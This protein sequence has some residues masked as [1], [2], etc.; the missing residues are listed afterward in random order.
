MR[1]DKDITH[2]KKKAEKFQGNILQDPVVRQKLMEKDQEYQ[3]KKEREKQDSSRKKKRTDLG[4][5]SLE[6]LEDTN[7]MDFADPEEEE[8]TKNKQSLFGKFRKSSNAE[9]VHSMPNNTRGTE[10]SNF[11]EISQDDMVNLSA[12]RK[13]KRPVERA[14]M[15]TS[16]SGVQTSQPIDGNDLSNMSRESIDSTIT[17][18]KKGFF[19]NPFKKKSKQGN[20]QKVGISEA[21]TVGGDD[22]RRTHSGDNSDPLEEERADPMKKTGH[23]NDE[24]I[25][26]QNVQYDADM[27]AQVERYSEIRAGDDEDDTVKSFADGQSQRRVQ[28]QY[29][30]VP[31]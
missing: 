15:H 4:A 30:E 14:G 5:P 8:R 20:D 1:K 23:F 29:N 13:A 2:L 26:V 24:A 16:Y 22:N 3:M 31:D 19:F 10:L 7:D 12:D 11:A 25:V 18:K 17:K 28:H 9:Q 21:S 27:K 6:Y